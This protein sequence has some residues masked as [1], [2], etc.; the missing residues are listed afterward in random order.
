MTP[1][2]LV[3]EKDAYFLKL[4]TPSGEVGVLSGHTPSVF[5][6]GMGELVLSYDPQDTDAYFFIVRGYSHVSTE[7]VVVLTPFLE[8]LNDIDYKRA[9]ESEER[10]LKRLRSEDD[11]VD[12]LRAQI[13]L[14]RAQKRVHL[15]DYYRK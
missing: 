10:A 15:V 2:G 14:G 7:G 9:K 8:F 12:R 5:Q 6:L 11:K 13:S 1:K 3:L 4:P